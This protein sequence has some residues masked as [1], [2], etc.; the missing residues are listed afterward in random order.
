MSDG[1]YGP[2]PFTGDDDGV[3]PQ[4][5]IN[6]VERSFLLRG[7]AVDDRTKVR[8]L[9][10]WLSAEGS[11]KE[12]W[13]GLDEKSKA[14][15]DALR[16]AFDVQWPPKPVSSK[17]AEERHAVL[18]KLVLEESALGKRVGVDGSGEFSHV[19]WAN[20]LERLAAPLKDTSGLLI[21]VVRKS[22]PL[23]LRQL[24]GVK[25]TSWKEFCAA[26]CAVSTAELDEV[27]EVTKRQSEVYEAVQR[28]Q[29]GRTGMQSLQDA[30]A[31]ASIT[32]QQQSAPASARFTPQ[33]RLHATPRGATQPY[34]SSTS[35]QRSFRPDTERL[36]D[37]QRLALPQHPN[38]PAGVAAYNAQVAQWSSSHSGLSPNELRPY[39]LTPGTAPVMSGECWKCG[40][41]GHR[42]S[43]C[44]AATKVPL[45]EEKWRSIAAS[46][47]RRAGEVAAAGGDVSVNWVDA[48]GNWTSVDRADYDEFVIARY[49][50]E[51]QG[52][53]NGGGPSA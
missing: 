17:T 40:H 48:A 25:H 32:N 23:A 14:S 6:S 24:V 49:L 44:S 35:Q 28:L 37:V 30:M 27:L 19:V 51:Q 4:D 7:S 16:A 50:E 2:Q 43:E 13:D 3:N 47:R 46:I 34:A 41:V 5:F 10:L 22:M 42:S 12:W 33:P 20:K 38:T 1:R 52:Q 8:S 39:P 45:L 9:E 31:A 26:I 18:L 15:W 11:A 53:G 21:P 29:K 36:A